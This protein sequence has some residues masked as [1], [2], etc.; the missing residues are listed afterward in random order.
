LRRGWRT[1]KGASRGA[2]GPVARRLFEV[3][4][5]L[6]MPQWSSVKHQSPSAVLV[7]EVDTFDEGASVAGYPILSSRLP[8]QARANLARRSMP[9]P[10]D[11]GIASGLLTGRTCP[12]PA[13]Q[14]RAQA[15]LTLAGL[16]PAFGGALA[17]GRLHD[18]VNVIL[19]YQ[20]GDGGWATY[21]N[22]RSFSALEARRPCKPPGRA[23]LCATLG[24]VLP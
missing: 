18:C 21:E 8:G 24:F 12:N 6:P 16:G 9:R 15:A 19:S 7:Q 2:Q 3:M 17:A 1:S 13:R 23:L 10:I 22:T 5:L 4:L 20:N 11:A 14:R